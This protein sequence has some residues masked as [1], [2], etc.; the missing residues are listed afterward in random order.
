[1]ELRPRAE[2]P[3][4]SRGARE[5]Y[6]RCA[7]RL[8]RRPLSPRG[9][10]CADGPCLPESQRRLTEQARLLSAFGTGSL[11][12]GRAGPGHSHVS[13]RPSPGSL[14]WGCL[15]LASQRADTRT[16]QR[17]RSHVAASYPPG[18]CPDAIGI[19][20]SVCS[21]QHCYRC[22]PGLSGPPPHPRIPVVV[23]VCCKAV[24]LKIWEP[25]N[26]GAKCLLEH[27]L[28]SLSYTFF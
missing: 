22:G 2:A 7:G 5:A 14:A 19:A 17:S 1:M 18:C 23:S 6:G 28:Q 9:H 12:A 16:S 25:V 15:E 13:L 20:L 21:F 26:E 24:S 8:S 10:H 11:L 27:S 3:G 4:G